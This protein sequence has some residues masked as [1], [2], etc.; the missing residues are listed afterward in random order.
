MK[1]YLDDERPKP[2]GWVG[3]RWPAE[4]IAHCRRAASR[5]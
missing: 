3:V 2:E 4:A 1:V 5:N